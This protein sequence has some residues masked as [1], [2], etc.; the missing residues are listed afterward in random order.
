MTYE[1]TTRTTSDGSTHTFAWTDGR[2]D[3]QP[4]LQIVATMSPSPKAGSTKTI[5]S[6]DT[7]NFFK[8]L[9]SVCS[10]SFKVNDHKF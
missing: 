5:I 2:T 7:C 10:A 9:C 3:T 1:V 6:S 4:K 8:L